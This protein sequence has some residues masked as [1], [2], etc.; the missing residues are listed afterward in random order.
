MDSI[1]LTIIIVVVVI[2][3][4]FVKLSK[5]EVVY[6]Q[7]DVDDKK[8][9]VRDL[10][11]KQMASNM[12]ARVKSNLAQLANELNKN[13]DTEYVEYKPYIEQLMGKFD[14]IIINESS[15][16]SVYTSYSVNKGEQ[17]VFC[18]RSK[19]F[20]NT[21]HDVNLV[22]YVALHEIS[23]VACPEYGHTMLFKKIFALFTTVAIKIGTYQ[24]IKFA[25][26]P[27]EYCGLTISESII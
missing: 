1:K 12:L 3:L 22:M 25:E 4:L 6:V 5:K 19:T 10:P 20:K 27:T 18:L 8:Y 23:H 7:S 24:Y 9:L 13:K 26:Q 17:I 16:D 14:K 11:D 21:L 2:T 15:E